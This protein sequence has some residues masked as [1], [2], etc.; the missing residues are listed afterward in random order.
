VNEV[1]SQPGPFSPYDMATICGALG[2]ADG[3]FRWL[4]KAIE[5]RSVDVIWM[6][7]DP[8]LDPV[9]SDPRFTEVMA[10]LVPRTA[11]IQTQR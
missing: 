11:P 1:T 6:R 9:R 7:V 10:R 8:R 2:D 3:V 5:Q 4:G